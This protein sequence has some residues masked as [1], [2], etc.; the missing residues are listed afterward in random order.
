MQFDLSEE[1]RMIQKTARDFARKELAPV[2][3]EHNEK[4]IYPAEIIAKLA[5]LG[6]LGM[7]LPEKYGGVDL[8]TFSLALVLEEISRVCASTSV[9]IAFSPCPEA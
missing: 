3:K 2:A 8:G 1:E 7:T 6:F 9:A 5:E 4:G